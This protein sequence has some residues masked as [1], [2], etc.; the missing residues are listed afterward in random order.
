MTAVAG[1][2]KSRLVT[3]STF[4]THKLNVRTAFVNTMATRSTLAIE[5]ALAA[6][7]CVAAPPSITHRILLGLHVATRLVNKPPCQFQMTALAGQQQRCHTVLLPTTTK[8]HQ[9]HPP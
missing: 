9:S 2:H 8:P 5:T 4:N 3:L 7:A 1:A 6:P